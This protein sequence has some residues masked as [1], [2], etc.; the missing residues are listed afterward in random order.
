MKTQSADHFDNQVYRQFSDPSL[1]EKD[2]QTLKGIIQGIQS[3]D[4]VTNRECS[5][6][7]MWLDSRWKYEYKQP[8]REL[9]S[10]IKEAI[11]DDILTKEESANIIWFCN[12][13]IEKTGYFEVITS[14]IQRL[15]GIVKGIIIDDEINL[16]ELEY[17]DQ[18]LEDNELLKHIYPYNELYNFVTSIMQDKEISE[19]K[20]CAL[21]TFCTALTGDATGTS[22][23]LHISALHTD[24]CQINP[25]IY[26]PESTFCITGLSKKIKRREIAERIELYD[27]YVVD[28]IN[29]K[30]NYL[31]FCG[32]PNAGW[33]FTCYG[34]KIEQA[35]EHQKTGAKLVIVHEYDL[36]DHLDCI[37]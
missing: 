13:Y 21:L 15:T 35:I 14:G 27:G 29:A 18:W 1:I 28:N 19:E 24:F 12:L 31:I 7:Q 26:I 23:E 30:L 4:V 9:M 32:E 2:L 37:R 3:D 17:L 11:Q 25:H 10:I 22:N 20:H 36:Y 8:Y 33:A 6:L 34:R 5:E 16:K